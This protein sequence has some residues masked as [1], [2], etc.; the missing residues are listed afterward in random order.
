MKSLTDEMK[1]YIQYGTEERQWEFKPPM[2]WGNSRQERKYEITKAVYALSNTTNG[3]YIV[4]GIL[5]KMDRNNGVQFKRVGL[6]TRQYNSFDNDDD[7]GRFINAKANQGIKFEIYGGKVSINN[8]ETSFIVMKIFE[9]SDSTPVICTFNNNSK[10]PHNRLNV[11]CL[12]IRTINNPIESRVI[13]TSEEWKELIRRLLIRKEEILFDDLSIICKNFPRT[14]DH[15][16]KK[17]IKSATSEY[18]KFLKRDKL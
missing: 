7:I 16:V 14:K 1:R 15:Q 8:N 6:T 5:Q 17:M 11:G 4:I 10:N 3:G 13:R 9:S 2:F 18:D 12:Y